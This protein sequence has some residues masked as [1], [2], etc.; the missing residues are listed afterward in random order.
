NNL[1]LTKLC[2]ESLFRNTEHPNYEI[3][4]VDNHST[5][6]TPAFLEDLAAKQPKL[7]VILNSTNY[8]FAR[9][10][11]QAI[12]H[13]IGKLLFYSITTRLWPGAGLAG[14]YGICA[15]RRLV[16]LARSPIS[17]A[18]RPRSKFLTETGSRW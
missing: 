6:G 16:W 17:Q 14:C 12:S 8:G 9:A 13:A 11:N 7:N 15:I 2:L 4:V 5:D 1:A 10:N 3:I 18:M